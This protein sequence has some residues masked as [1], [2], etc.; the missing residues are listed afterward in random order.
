MT[1][2]TTYS[3][4]S[5]QRFGRH[6]GTDGKTGL[7]EVRSPWD[8]VDVD[9]HDVRCQRPGGAT[10]AFEIGYSGGRLPTFQHD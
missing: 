7:R 1:A 8:F 5:D 10:H 3:Q 4:N 2:L 6:H 9:R